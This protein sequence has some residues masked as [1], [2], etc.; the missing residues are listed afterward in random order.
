MQTLAFKAISIGA[1]LLIPVHASRAQDPRAAR[2]PIVFSSEEL[3]NLVAPIALYPD[4]LLAQILI[5]AT[6]PEQVVIAAR[7]VRERGTRGVDDEPWDLSVKAV[8]HYP[9][10]LNMLS[11]DDD[12]SAALGQ[13]YAGQSA[14]VMDAVQR[15]REMAREQGNLV[16]T[17]EQT[18]IVE[19]RRIVIVP[20]QPQVI[21]V[22][23]YD[24]SVVFFRPVIH[25]GFRTG[26]WSFGIGFPIGDWLVYDFD[27][28]GRRIYYDG[29]AGGGWRVLA[30]PY[31]QLRPIYVHH[32]YRTIHVGNVYGRFVN[33]GNLDRRYRRVHD[34]VTWA[35]HDRNWRGPNDRA[36]TGDRDRDGR[37]PGRVGAP[38]DNDRGPDLFDGRRTPSFDQLRPERPA[39][40]APRTEPVR[41]STGFGVLDKRR[42]TPTTRAT[43]NSSTITRNRPVVK[44]PTSR[45]PA[46][47]S[48]P[49][50][51]TTVRKSTIAPTRS[52]PPRTTT[53]AQAPRPTLRAPVR[54][55]PPTARVQMAKPAK[56]SSS[57]GSVRAAVSRPA[58]AK[59]RPSGG[60]GKPSGGNSKAS[61]G[62]GGGR[63]K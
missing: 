10:V 56:V 21:Y 1:L 63:S 14:D 8:A 24:P 12:W 60:N 7:H 19:N 35:R 28:Y 42:E 2:A 9:P 59:A 33:F 25:L 3:D 58:A 5:A 37:G 4:A 46:T 6:Y 17:D 40:T 29:W 54:S 52:A 20:A 49:T 31:I 16:S 41:T 30:R 32:R 34:R 62:K 57:G 18:V 11:E 61:G 26:Y 27:W 38:R 13:A 50:R 15:L 36:R 51:P 39:R 44:E 55:A 45:R 23:T 22:P 43:I 53:R 48:T 47:F